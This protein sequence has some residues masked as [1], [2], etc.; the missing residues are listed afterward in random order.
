MLA[1]FDCDPL[2]ASAA[3]ALSDSGSASAGAMKR[4]ANQR[5]GWLVLLFGRAASLA[6][7][8]CHASYAEVPGLGGALAGSPPIHAGMSATGLLPVLAQPASQPETRM[9]MGSPNFI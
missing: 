5:V 2:M 1:L 8:A 3:T 4:N 6:R 9:K 7:S